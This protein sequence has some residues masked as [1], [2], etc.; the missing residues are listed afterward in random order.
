LKSAKDGVFICPETGFRYRE[1]EH[2]R[3]QCVDLPEDQPLPAELT[4]GAK[5]YDEFKELL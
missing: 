1:V 3:L 5:A 4:V 2:N